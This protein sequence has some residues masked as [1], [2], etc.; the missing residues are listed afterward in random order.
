MKTKSSQIPFLIPFNLFFFFFFLPPERPPLHHNTPL[1]WR[2]TV[3]SQCQ[4]LRTHLLRHTQVLSSA[5]WSTRETLGRNR[6]TRTWT[7][8][9]PQLSSALTSATSMT[10]RPWTPWGLMD[11]SRILRVYGSLRQRGLRRKALPKHNLAWI[12]KSRAHL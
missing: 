11:S 3:C 4:G 8:H 12:V 9:A 1:S 6:Q 2:P 5:S 10:N 7:A